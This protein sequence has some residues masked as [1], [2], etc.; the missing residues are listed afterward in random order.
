MIFLFLLNTG[1]CQADSAAIYYAM[2]KLDGALVHKDEK[3][4]KDLLHPEV[5]YGHSN[6]WI[7]NF[8]D[9]FKDFVS[10]KLEYAK[11]KNNSRRVLQINKDRATVITNTDVEGT[12]NGNPFKLTL[13]VMLVW[14]KTNTGW[15]LIA[16]QSTKL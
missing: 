10:G 8:D 5:S 2:D 3:A 7:Q 1:F 6:G 16:R 11:I 4:L 9:V 15:Q 13:H 12:G 14:I